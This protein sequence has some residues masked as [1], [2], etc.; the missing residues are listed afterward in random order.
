MCVAVVVN[1]KVIVIGGFNGSNCLKTCE[2]YDPVQNRW[3]SL[4]A[5]TTKRCDACAVVV[6]GKVIVIGGLG[7]KVFVKEGYNGYKR[8]KTCEEYA[9][10]PV[11]Q[12]QSSKVPVSK[13]RPSE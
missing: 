6:N 13:V 10:L 12:V 3:C 5:M 8:L 9:P 2:E 11:S 4:P 7:G 1:G